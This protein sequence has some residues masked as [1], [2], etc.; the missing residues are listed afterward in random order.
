M[1]Q[2]P[3]DGTPVMFNI[4]WHH[5]L[6]WE[7]DFPEE[8]TAGREDVYLG[9]FYRTWGARPDAIAKEAA[10]VFALLPPAGRDARRLHFSYLSLTT[11]RER[12]TPLR[13]HMSVPLRHEEHE[14]TR[15]KAGRNRQ[16]SMT[17]TPRWIMSHRQSTH[18]SLFH[19]PFA[20]L[21]VSS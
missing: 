19:F 4:R 6:H 13:V 17:M 12:H 20:F 16:D 10:G 11:R 1:C 2:V 9:F 14:E 21:R 7:V 15:R 8:L 5:G 3:G 18:F